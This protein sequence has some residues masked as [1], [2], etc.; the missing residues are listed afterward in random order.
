[1]PARDGQEWQIVVDTTNERERGATIDSA[2]PLTV[3]SRSVVVVTA[4]AR[5]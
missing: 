5:R 2:K 3:A 1:M 4:Q